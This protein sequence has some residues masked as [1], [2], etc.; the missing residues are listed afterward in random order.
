MH[1]IGRN[2]VC[3]CGS[4]KKYKKCCLVNN[5]PSSDELAWRRVHDAHTRVIQKL[6]EFTVK[7][8]GPIGY[9]EAWSEFNLWQTDAPFDPRTPLHPMFGPWMFYH[10]RPDPEETE[11]GAN[12]P[13]DVSPAEYFLE[14]YGHR[15]EEIEIED[16]EENM[17][18]PYSFYDVLDCQPGSWVKVQDL[19]TEEYF[20]VIEKMGSQSMSAGDLLFGKVV[21]VRDVSMFDGLAPFAFP[22]RFKVDVIRLRE[23]FSERGTQLSANNLRDLD[24]E[25]LDLFWCLHEKVTN[26]PSPILTNTDGHLFVPHKVTF[27]ISSIDETFEAL[28]GLNFNNTRDELLEM[29]TYSRDGKMKS[30]EFPW[31]MKGNTKNKHW[32]NTVLGHIRLEE[33]Q[34]TVE[35]NSKERMEKF[36]TVLKKRMPSGWELEGT[37]VE[38]VRTKMREAKVSSH[39]GED[40]KNKE[41][42]ERPEVQAFL[43]E[44]AEGHWASWP[45]TPLPALG[46]MTPVEAIKTKSGRAM[47]EALITD[48]ERRAED[49]SVL[50]QNPKTFQKLRNRLGL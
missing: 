23:D 37:L 44:M 7:T 3:P 8:Y 28:H 25:L 20:T 40:F 38:D 24:I 4:G 13:G 42:N 19:F 2:D 41:L 15:L 9:N 33:D 47:V 5:Q 34:M 31:L 46:G 39:S 29:A 50:G 10:W 27:A 48:F 49:S 14:K 45:M 1:N 18:R 26:P 17:R 30:V 6:M 11:L 22:P 35:V 32:D 43:A 21:T 36:L 12:I 16:L